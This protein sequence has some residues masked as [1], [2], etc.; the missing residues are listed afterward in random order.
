MSTYKHY[1]LGQLYEAK[2]MLRTHSVEAFERKYPTLIYRFE[3][4]YGLDV[5][6]SM[7]NKTSAEYPFYL[8]NWLL[9]QIN[10]RRNK[11]DK[12]KTKTKTKTENM[13]Q[14]VTC[15]EQATLK[16]KDCKNQSQYY[17]SEE[18]H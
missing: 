16:C 12:A 14:C 13:K 17:C 18:C 6:L 10:K 5:P 1:T 7:T 3:R 9:E 8:D 11:M 4:D 2:E 15:G